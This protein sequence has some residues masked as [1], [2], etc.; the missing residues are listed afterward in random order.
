MTEEDTIHVR[1]VTGV[2]HCGIACQGLAGVGAGDRETNAHVLLMD[3]AL[4]GSQNKK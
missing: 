1:K 4:H 2:T 3:Y